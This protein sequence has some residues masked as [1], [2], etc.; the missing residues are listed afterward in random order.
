MQQISGRVFVVGFMLLV[1]CGRSGWGI[2]TAPDGAFTVLMPGTPK[3]KE[4]ADGWH[5]VSSH[6]GS[7]RD[8]FSFLVRYRDFPAPV[9]QAQFKQLTDSVRDSQDPDDEF[10]LLNEKAITLDGHPGM[11]WQFADLRFDHVRTVRAC[12]VG[13]RLYSVTASAPKHRAS[14]PQVQQFLDSF[15]ISPRPGG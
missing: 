7:G 8:L 6:Q 10:R 11:E 15:R 5:L 14:D 2:Y 3:V 4:E 13:N 1:G 12:A 9:P